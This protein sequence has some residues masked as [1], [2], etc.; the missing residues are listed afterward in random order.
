MDKKRSRLTRLC[1][2]IQ[3]HLASKLKP[4]ISKQP[5]LIKKIDEMLAA[6]KNTA[7]IAAEIG[8]SRTTVQNY[9]STHAKEKI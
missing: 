9:I 3:V 1:Y 5:A 4:R 8:Y 7:Q 6:G 2:S